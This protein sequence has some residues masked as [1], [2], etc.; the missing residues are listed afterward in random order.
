[1]PTLIN[2]K[3]VAD[4]VALD[5]LPRVAV[6]DDA[7]QHVLYLDG[8]ALPLSMLASAWLATRGPLPNDPTPAEIDAA[9]LAREAARQ[10]AVADAAALRQQV[11]TI[12]QSAVGIR[13]DQLTAGQVRALFA[14]LL[15]KEGA[16]K[17]DL[18]VRA[19]SEWVKG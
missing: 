16:L 14:V 12:A 15:H 18:T 9:I 1:M 19:L 8:G 13:V 17:A 2:G 6:A 3:A 4:L 10:A 11:L 7:S 5:G